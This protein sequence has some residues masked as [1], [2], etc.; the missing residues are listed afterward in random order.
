MTFRGSL[1]EVIFSWNYRCFWRYSTLLV[2]YWFWTLLV[3]EVTFWSFWYLGVSFV[4]FYKN[5]RFLPDFFFGQVVC[6]QFHPSVALRGAGLALSQFAPCG[7]Q[8]T[9]T[10]GNTF[11]SHFFT[12]R[13]RVDAMLPMQFPTLDYTCLE[14]LFVYLSSTIV[15]G[16][17]QGV[18]LVGR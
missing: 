3:H 12:S 18:Y 6:W 5:C 10:Y 9:A 4:L 16:M 15:C 8:V 11:P 1:Y 2:H 13:P 14:S 7:C 17:G